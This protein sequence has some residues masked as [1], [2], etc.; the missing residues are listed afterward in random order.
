MVKQIFDNKI[1]EAQLLEIKIPVNFPTVTD[2]NDYEEIAGQ[3][4]LKDAFYNYVRL[5]ITR[6]TMYLICLPNTFKTRV[7]NANII[8]A[9]E[10]SDVPLTK[11]GHNPATK[12]GN[13]FSEF[14]IAA[15]Q[16]Y[17]SRFG[18]FLKHGPTSISLDF[19]RPFIDSPGKPPNFIS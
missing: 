1:N 10:I 7:V 16:Y 4:Q 2:W 5:K 15:F 13:L 3:I 19:N 14:K 11:N 8:A 9:K 18:I 6:D 12:K 17:H